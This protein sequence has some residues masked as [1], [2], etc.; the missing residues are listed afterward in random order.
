MNHE[1]PFGKRD[2]SLESSGNGAEESGNASFINAVQ[3]MDERC[4]TAPGHRLGP[5][6]GG[7]DGVQQRAIP[8]I[9]Q[10]APAAFDQ[11]VLAVVRRIVGQLQRQLMPALRTPPGVS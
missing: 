7:L 11:V 4:D 9:L 10:N 3:E 2:G 6:E 5:G 1:A 8:V